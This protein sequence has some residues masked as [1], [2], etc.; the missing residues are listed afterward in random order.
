[1]DLQENNMSN[2]EDIKKIT[3]ADLQA[4]IDILI[5]LRVDV[6]AGDIGAVDR[7]FDPENSEDGDESR[8][9]K[10][11]MIFLLRHAD[12]MDQLGEQQ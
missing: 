11:W 1:M 3:V 4:V 8:F 6:A 2:F 10:M 5:E 9:D 12:R 7:F